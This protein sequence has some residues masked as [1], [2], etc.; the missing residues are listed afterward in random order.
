M[1]SEKVPIIL[2]VARVSL[3][4][5][6]YVGDRLAEQCGTDYSL[7][8]LCHEA[9]ILLDSGTSATLAPTDPPEAQNGVTAKSPGL[10]CGSLGV[11]NWCP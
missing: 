11:G 7:Q 2:C 8:P 9:I 4:T 6:R 1:T 5:I 3:R 10:I